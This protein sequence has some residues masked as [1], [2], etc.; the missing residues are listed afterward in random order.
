MHDQPTAIEF[1]YD[2]TIPSEKNAPRTQ[3]AGKIFNDLRRL[4]MLDAKGVFVYLT[5]REMGTYLSN[6]ANGL[7]DF[8]LLLRASSSD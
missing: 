7:S 1:K 3:K 8:F 6:P 5:D 4:A 2:R